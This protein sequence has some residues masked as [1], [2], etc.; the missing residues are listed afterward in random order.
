MKK[1]ID[2]SEDDELRSSYLQHLILN[3]KKN[4]SKTPIAIPKTIIHYWH[5][6]NNIPK[7]V[8]QCLSSW[9]HLSKKGFEQKIF[10]NLTSSQYISNNLSERE[11]LAYEKCNHP[12]MRCDYFRLCYLYENGG[13]YIDADELYQ[14]ENILHLL[15]D[16]RLKIQPMVYDLDLNK[17]VKYNEF[18]MLGFKTKNKIFYVNNNPIFS[19][20]RNKIIKTA[21]V[22]A[23]KLL[24]SNNDNYFDIQS[25]TGPGNL[26]A[27]IVKHLSQKQ[28]SDGLDEISFISDWDSISISKWPLSYR[29]DNRNWRHWNQNTNYDDVWS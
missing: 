13:I 28:D 17:M 12:A 19:P 6:K 27:S 3:D 8:Q 15:A 20:P 7:D 25:T 2:I 22:R 26:S 24:L 23:T 9:S 11:V 5:D 4:K 29:D 21:L 16:N 10:C 18:T 1:L 14:N